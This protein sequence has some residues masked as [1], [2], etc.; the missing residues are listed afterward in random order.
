P[1]K[2]RVPSKGHHHA[3][4]HSQIL[5]R[6]QGLRLHLA[7]RWRQRQLRPHHRRAGG[8]HADAQQ[9]SAPA[10][11]SRTGPQRQGIGG[12][13]GRRLGAADRFSGRG[14]RAAPGLPYPLPAPAGDFPMSQTFDFYDTR[15]REAA[16]EA[17]RAE[18]VMVRERALRA[19]KTWRGLANQARKIE[20]DRAKAEE[21]RAER[22]AAEAEAAAMALADAEVA[23]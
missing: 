11:R 20:R 10:V 1:G 22:R 17:D 18:L 14:P 19:E 13:S 6:R 2:P 7:R 23:E 15:A 16:A 4:R 3:G 21:I 8:G 5:Q 12:Q 9:G